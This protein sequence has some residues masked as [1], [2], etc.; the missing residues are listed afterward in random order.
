[1]IRIT[2]G[3]D[4]REAV[5]YHTFCQSIIDK[6]SQPVSFTPLVLSA[7]SGYAE[8]HNDGS[9]AFI[10]SRFLTPFLFGFQGWA[11]FADGDMICRDDIAKL[12]ALRDESKAVMCA[13]HEYKTKAQDKYLGN[14]NQDY[15][16]KNWS[17]VVLWNCGHPDNRI[18]TPEFVQ[19]QTGAI[20]HRFTWLK[21][22]Q[23]GEIPKE[24][25]WLT[26]EYPDNYDA[27]LLHY[28]LGT[29]CFKDY[30]SSDMADEW[31]SAYE[32]TQK[33]MHV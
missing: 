23:V 21:D 28:T 22:E 20:L 14:K 33:G 26:T 19:E 15:P 6:S 7:L 12:W 17:S 18:L 3:Y 27:K 5:A 25:N 8:K 16:R 4:E 29:P 9:N 24:W 31:H 32:R 11:I 2:I 10:Y 13:K 1:M 30:W